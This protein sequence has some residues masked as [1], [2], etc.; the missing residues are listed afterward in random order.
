VRAR[1]FSLLEAMVTLVVLALVATLL[2]QS[3]AHV[4]SLR[5][6]L[7]RHERDARVQ[8]L[9][10]QWFRDSVA[11]AVADLAGER[12]AFVGDATGMAFLSLDALRSGS[13]ATVA[14]RVEEIDD[15]RKLVY[16]EG[17]EQ[18]MLLGDGLRAGRFAYLDAGG[19]WHDAWPL[20]ERPDEVLPRAVR[21][22]IEEADGTRDWRAH[23]GAAPG[24]PPV[25]ANR[26][27]NFD[28]AF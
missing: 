1:G 15:R 3:L 4:L 5:E 2:M 28:G 24:L 23:V 19:H 18:W 22:D 6:R 13:A 9:H 26:V 10:E 20:E 7:L 17:G 11:A 25:L 21:L 16:V 14:W 12:P 27:R 8:A